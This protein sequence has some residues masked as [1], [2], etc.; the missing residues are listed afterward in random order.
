MTIHQP[1]DFFVGLP[2][3]LLGVTGL[4]ID[5]WKIAKHRF[6]DT[7][8]DW[9]SL[10]LSVWFITSGPARLSRAFDFTHH[11]SSRTNV[12]EGVEAVVLGV[13]IVVTLAVWIAR[14]YSAQ[15][16]SLL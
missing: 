10:G 8:G 12:L 11:N 2:M 13:I 4:A 1:I 16:A 5:L 15:R 14:R 7:Y 6:R 3:L 9:R